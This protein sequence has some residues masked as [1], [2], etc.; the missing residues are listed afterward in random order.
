MF[1]LFKKKPTNQKADKAISLINDQL[2]LQVVPSYK[3][4]RDAFP[5]LMTNKL[6]AGYVFG[7]QDS[8]FQTF[9][10]LDPKEHEAGSLLIRSSYQSIFGDEAGWA[11]YE[12][13][14]DAQMDSEF[15]IGRQSGGEEFLEGIREKTPEFGLGHWR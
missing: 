6:A 13:S 12:M 15:D 5:V 4:L 11:L 7:F 10:L 8:C 9:G 2:T 3:R 14:I 1:G